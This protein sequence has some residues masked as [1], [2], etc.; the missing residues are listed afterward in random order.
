MLLFI[1]GVSSRR[2]NCNS[3]TSFRFPIFDSKFGVAV[4]Y[5]LAEK[6]A[7]SNTPTIIHLSDRD[8]VQPH[9]DYLLKYRENSFNDDYHLKFSNSSR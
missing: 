2:E 3:E 4:R 7:F 6:E 9:N 1:I 8:H 5:C